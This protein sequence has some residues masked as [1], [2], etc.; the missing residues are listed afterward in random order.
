MLVG[1]GGFRLYGGG[2]SVK[3]GKA[4]RER[5]DEAVSSHHE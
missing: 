2:E 4:A 5:G 1:N 3:A